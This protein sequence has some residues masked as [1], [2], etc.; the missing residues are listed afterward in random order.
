MAILIDK[1]L[2]EADQVVT[3]LRS[4][5]PLVELPEKRTQFYTH[6]LRSMEEGAAGMIHKSLARRVFCLPYNSNW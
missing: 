1:E 6:E 2:Q 3:S 5:F 4:H